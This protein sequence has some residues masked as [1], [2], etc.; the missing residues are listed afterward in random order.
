MIFLKKNHLIRFKKELKDHHLPPLFIWVFVFMMDD[1]ENDEGVLLWVKLF[2]DDKG[3]EDDVDRLAMGG[4][5]IGI[6]G[7]DDEDDDRWCWCPPPP[8]PPPVFAICI[9]WCCCCCCWV[10]RTVG[11]D[12]DVVDWLLGVFVWCWWCWAGVLDELAAG[13]DVDDDDNAFILDMRSFL[14]KN[15]FEK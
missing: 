3:D 6:G 2:E 1:E 7:L 15:N 14:S 13:A 10:V 5:D 8:P 9:L 11:G 4:G 12:G